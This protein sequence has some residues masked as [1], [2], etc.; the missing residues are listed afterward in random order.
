M[1]RL[2]KLD[3]RPATRLLAAL[4]A[5]ALVLF[6]PAAVVRAQSNTSSEAAFTGA[7]RVAL[8]LESPQGRYLHSTGSGFVVAPNY[9][10]TA[11]HVVAPAR[12][13]QG[14]R[15]SIVAPGAAGPAEAQVVRFSA[16]QDLAILR[17][18]GP[19]P[20]PLT[21]STVTPSPG[22]AVVALGYPDMDDLR[23]PPAEI[24]RPTP[25]SRSAGAIASLRDRAPTGDPIP[26]INHE[27]AISSG[28]SGGPLLDGCGR[29]IGVNSWHARGGETL[30]ARGVA[31]RVPPLVEF[32]REAN[33]SP[34]LSDD[35]CVTA[36]ERAEAE[37][38]AAVAALAEQN[39]D[40]RRRLAEADRLTRFTL[41]A[42]VAGGV[43]FLTSLAMMMIALF[44][45]RRGAV[46]P[47]PS[48]PASQNAAAQSAP[49]EPRVEP[50]DDAG[51][52]VV[53]PPTTAA[54]TPVASADE[55]ARRR[56]WP[57][58]VLIAAAAVA[59]GFVLPLAV[60]VM[61]SSADMRR[62]AGEA[63]FAG[64]HICRFDPAASGVREGADTSF[65]IDAAGCVNARTLYAPA[66]GGLLKRVVLNESRGMIEVV[67]LSTRTGE[68]RRE[69]FALTDERLAEARAAARETPAPERCEASARTGVARRNAALQHFV[70]G[71]PVQ[72]A[73]WRCQKAP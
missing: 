2:P 72:R 48:A 16:L 4:A 30:S 36:L 22:D 71:Q 50:I 10:V 8:I 49:L 52:L 70:T 35:R 1:G 68:F 21:I 23:S 63:D 73:V 27:A 6:A 40:I 9:V 13:I 26:T 45:M 60:Q 61:R 44:G 33:I 25:P 3:R 64:R 19:S 67:T 51:D 59:I 5:A 43:L 42:V 46:A 57:M 38:D 41:F 32:L 53:L 69:H 39:D 7:V 28:S 15:I 11:A 55:P 54:V 29:V 31:I 65:A 17:F 56:W 47:A 18:D 58:A 34:D 24:V 37:R 62:A 20:P 12:Q 14:I 66:S